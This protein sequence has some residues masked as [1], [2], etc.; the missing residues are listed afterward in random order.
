MLKTLG[1]LFFSCLTALAVFS[2]DKKNITDVDLIDALHKTYGI[3]A[4]KRASHAKGFCYEGSFTASPEAK[5]YCKASLFTNSK[6][7]LIGRFSLAG[8]NPKASDKSRSARGMSVRFSVSKKEQMDFVFLSTPVFF[9]STLSEFVGFLGARIPD[10]ITHKPNPETVK[11]FAVQNPK[12][13]KQSK[14]LESHPIPA[15]YSGA[16]YY[17]VHAF[18]IANN[19]KETKWIKWE[20][21]PVGGEKSLTDEDIK[22]KTDTFYK[23]QL[24]HELSAGAVDFDLY[25][26]LGEAGDNTT[27]PTETWADNRKKVKMGTLS[28][29]KVNEQACDGEMFS[30]TKLLKGIAPS[31]DPILK[32]RNSAYIISILGRAK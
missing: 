27:D 29:T 18:Q 21:V 1:V 5:D 6:T 22:T 23:E 8:G 12:T 15:S 32:A 11:A 10:S 24:Q 19:K 25:A 17:S 16:T 3:H 26:V 4:Q 7:P 9:A 14:W 13:T 30:P 28:I 20:L 2:Q 31:E